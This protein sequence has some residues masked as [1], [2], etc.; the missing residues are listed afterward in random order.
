MRF[1]ADLRLAEDATRDQL[2]QYVSDH[3]I[4]SSTWDLIRHRVVTEYAFKVGASPGIVLFL[5][6]DSDEAAIDVVKAL[7]VVESGLLVF[8]IDPVRSV[9]RF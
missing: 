5:E 7:P 9:A 8:E 2:V 4:E 1:I 6:A 3:A